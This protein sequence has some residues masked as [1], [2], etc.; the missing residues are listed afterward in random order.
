[1]AGATHFDHEGG[2]STGSAF[3]HNQDEFLS[4]RDWLS[5]PG[6]MD[7][8]LVAHLAALARRQDGLFSRAQALEVGLRCRDIDRWLR[9]GHV[10]EHWPQVYG[11][12]TAPASLG[13]AQRAALLAAG[14]QALL[15][16][17]NVAVRWLFD[18]PAPRGMWLTCPIDPGPLGWTAS[19][20]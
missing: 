20:S 10:R 6:P 7:A 2:P 12:A 1:M 5:Q 14:K 8:D 16:Q 17:D 9:Q 18:V 19:T 11:A 13:Q 4:G 3:V 15:S